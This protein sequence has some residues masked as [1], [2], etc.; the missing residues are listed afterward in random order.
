MLLV[1][2]IQTWW[3]M[4]NIW[5]QKQVL[6]KPR[7]RG[8]YIVTGEILNVIDEIETIDVGVA[9]FFIMHTSAS[10]TI[11]ENTDRDVCEDL[12][13]YMSEMVS[14]KFQWKHIFE[15]ED[16]M[17]AHVK[18]SIIGAHLNIPIANGSLVLGMWQGICLWEFRNSGPARKV[19]I[20][21][22]GRLRT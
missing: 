18:N 6:L 22:N 1:R 14:E 12:E 20:T 4:E 10:L 17:P 9:N 3:K 2:L 13:R 7:K 11:T 15:G 19:M 16:D 5:H 8:C 21:L